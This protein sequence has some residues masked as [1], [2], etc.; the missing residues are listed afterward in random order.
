LIGLILTLALLAALAFSG[1]RILRGKRLR[2]RLAALPGGSSETAIEIE[3][4]ADIEEH[5]DKRD[6]RCGGALR[7][8][9]ERSERAGDHILRVVHVECYRCEETQWLYFN[10]T[11]VYQ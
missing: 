4:F 7:V 8:L 3:S 9:G 10:A 6:C 5:L 1:E 2:R 11:Q